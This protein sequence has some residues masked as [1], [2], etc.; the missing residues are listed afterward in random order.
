MFGRGSRKV[1]RETE[2]R[3]IQGGELAQVVC[4]IIG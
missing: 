1:Y 3:G 4:E 2:T